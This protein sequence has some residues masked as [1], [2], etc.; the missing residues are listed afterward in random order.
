VAD[1]LSIDRSTLAFWGE[2]LRQQTNPWKRFAQKK[3]AAPWRKP[4]VLV[5]VGRAAENDYRPAFPEYHI[6]VFLSL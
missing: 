3:L 2:R 5:G 1:A 6:F 4:P